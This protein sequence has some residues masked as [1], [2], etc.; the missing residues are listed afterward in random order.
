[1]DFSMIQTLN[2]VWLMQILDSCLSWTVE[3]VWYCLTSVC[4]FLTYF[5]YETFCYLVFRNNFNREMMRT[6][7]HSSHHSVLRNRFTVTRC[8]LTYCSD[9]WPIKF[10]LPHLCT[11]YKPQSWSTAHFA[12]LSALFI[13]AALQPDILP[14]LR[15]CQLWTS[16][17]IL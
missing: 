7:H 4:Y 8:L 1:M 13:E 17:C 3:S 9:L 10:I 6:R 2:F 14:C 16:T 5:L 11:D 12:R 15:L